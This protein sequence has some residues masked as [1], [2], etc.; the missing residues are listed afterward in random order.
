M[1]KY[2]EFKSIRVSV[3]QHKPHEINVNFNV[4]ALLRGSN[5]PSHAI[6]A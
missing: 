5:I 4:Y 1:Y 6:K 3:N 2:T